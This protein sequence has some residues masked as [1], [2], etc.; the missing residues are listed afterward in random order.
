MENPPRKML[1]V[2]SVHAACLADAL[3]EALAS[4][5]R[6]TQTPG[7]VVDI[8]DGTLRQLHQ[9]RERAVGESAGALTPRSGRA[10]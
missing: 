8:I 2:A 6:D 10:A 9:I 7:A 3:S 4:S 1:A 5:A